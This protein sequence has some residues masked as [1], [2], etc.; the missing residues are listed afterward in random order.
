MHTT[1]T[2]TWTDRGGAQDASAS[3]ASGKFFSFFFFFSLLTIF[4][5]QLDC[6]NY[7][8]GDDK[9][10]RWVRPWWPGWQTAT[11][12]MCEGQERENGG[13][14]D[15]RQRWCI[16]RPWYIYFFFFFILFFSYFLIIS[17]PWCIQPPIHHPQHPQSHLE[18]N[19]NVTDCPLHVPWQCQRP[20]KTQEMGKR[21]R[22]DHNHQH[23][24]WRVGSSMTI[25]FPL[26]AVTCMM[27]GATR[28]GVIWVGTE[29][30]G[31]FCFVFSGSKVVKIN[32]FLHLNMLE[33]P[34][35]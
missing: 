21:R 8:N 30:W 19:N 11:Q 35:E 4:F 15:S 16:S 33:I 1:N 28:T 23:L 2:N 18:C 14:R 22:W 34:P 24:E 20:K 32:V 25:H 26:Q 7:Y 13:S 9:Q 10:G 17:S 3:R 27:R 31:R 5:L 6:I 29:W 12:M